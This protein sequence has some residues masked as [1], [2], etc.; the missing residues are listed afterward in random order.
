MW[1]YECWDCIH[2]GEGVCCCV[3]EDSEEITYLTLSL[4]KSEDAFAFRA[5]LF[6]VIPERGVIE[7]TMLMASFLEELVNRRAADK[8]RVIEASDQ[9]LEKLAPIV[10]EILTRRI[11]DNKRPLG[12]GAVTV[13]ARQG[14]WHASLKHK[15]L[16]M[17]WWAEGSSFREA[18]KGLE[19]A[20]REGNGQ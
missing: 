14:L 20:L 13:F 12:T 11:V 19:G 7:R 8:E 3:N 15:G 17:S 2:D 16:G 10:Y 4:E 5:W 9:E 1:C 18:L 6:G